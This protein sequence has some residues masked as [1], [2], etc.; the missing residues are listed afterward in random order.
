MC[1]CLF[2]L[3]ERNVGMNDVQKTTQHDE[4]TQSTFA[5]KSVE[6][7]GLFFVECF[8]NQLGEDSN[9]KICSARLKDVEFPP[10]SINQKLLSF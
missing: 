5:M 1:V 3:R 10:T 4:K 9:A 8:F 2:L 7:H 6:L